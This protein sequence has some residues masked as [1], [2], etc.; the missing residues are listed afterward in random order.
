MKIILTNLFVIDNEEENPEE[1]KKQI[2]RQK[3]R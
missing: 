1:E 3:I 2:K